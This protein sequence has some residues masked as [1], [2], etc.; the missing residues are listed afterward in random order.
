MNVA[1]DSRQLQVVGSLWS[2]TTCPETGASQCAAAFYPVRISML[3]RSA[4]FDV[5][6]G[7]AQIGPITIGDI[8]YG[9]DVR[10]E[11]DEFITD[12]HVNVPISG[13]LE[14]RHRGIEV[15]STPELA[16]LYRPG[17]ATMITRWPAGSRHLVVKIDRTAIDQVLD[18][19]LG[20]AERSC[21]TFGASMDTTSG[22]GR[23]WVQML[24]MANEQLVHKCG[25]LREPLV[26][27]PFAESL[28]YGLLLAADNPHREALVAPAKPAA[29]AAIRTAIDI[30]EAA[31][32]EPLTTA[33]LA[34]D[35]HVSVRALQE[36]FRRHVG[37]SPMAYVRMVR[38]DRAHEQLRSADP[39]LT[40][41]ASIAHRWGFTHLGR[42]AA[43]HAAKY[44]EAPGQTLYTTR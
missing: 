18:R 44:G 28:I 19:H 27:A 34:A 14:S 11:F 9:V 20:P 37:M 13:R 10:L 31:P 4:T 22:A 39:S 30:I 29:P 43:A 24:R 26:A 15:T 12:Y 8:T 5:T 1:G 17:G 40:T 33:G 35:C 42:F 41:V 6:H 36:G 16:A 7:V 21:V 23:S 32:D 2:R 38:L 25:V 3:N